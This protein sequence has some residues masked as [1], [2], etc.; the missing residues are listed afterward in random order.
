MIIHTIDRNYP[1]LQD[2]VSMS[3]RERDRFI[4]LAAE[5]IVF[6]SE[7][8]GTMFSSSVMDSVVLRKLRSNGVEFEV[9]KLW[10]IYDATYDNLFA[11]GFDR[12][13]LNCYTLNCSEQNEED[14]NRIVLDNS[15]FSFF[16]TY[17]DRNEE[18]L[19]Q[20]FCEVV[21]P[22]GIYKNDVEAGYLILMSCAA[23]F[24]CE[25]KITKTIK[26]MSLA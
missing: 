5:S 24:G 8:D 17:A 14:L 13:K 12:K 21:L 2:Y 1:G 7:M 9:E 11:P 15:S 20:F 23:L 26:T 10:A 3:G 25:S 22:D 4:V 16:E 18:M 6:A 19:F